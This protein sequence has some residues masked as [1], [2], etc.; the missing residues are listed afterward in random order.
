MQR[1]PDSYLIIP[2]CSFVTVCISVDK[3]FAP[4]HVRTRAT[5]RVSDQL[6]Q[7]LI[8]STTRTTY[9]VVV[10]KMSGVLVGF[11]ILVTVV[12]VVDCIL[13]CT[14][15]TI[16]TQIIIQRPCKNKHGVLSLSQPCIT[17]PDQYLIFIYSVND[18]TK[19]Y[20]GTV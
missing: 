16:I 18:K 1:I 19:E 20:V 11:D 17:T 4:R 15:D 10:S 6:R 12:L 3:N 13:W 8:Q 7:S 5:F 2:L 9:F 14:L